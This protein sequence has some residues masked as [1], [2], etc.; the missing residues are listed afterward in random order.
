M[1]K[2]IRFCVLFSGFYIG[3]A[4]VA[5]MVC[6]NYGHDALGMHL[7]MTPVAYLFAPVWCLVDLMPED[8]IESAWG[9]SLLFS[10]GMFCIFGN[11]SFWGAIVLA[12]GKG[13]ARVCHSGR[14][15]TG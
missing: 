8:V 7:L 11:G 2:A 6:Q 9:A 10:L 14:Q 4:M 1:V 15:L 3:P 13:V 12:F 5:C